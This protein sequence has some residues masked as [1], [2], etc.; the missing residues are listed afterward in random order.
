MTAHAEV[1]ASLAEWLHLRKPDTHPMIFSEVALTGKFSDAGRLDVVAV[2]TSDFY[3]KVTIHGWEVKATRSDLLSD[4]RAEKWRRYLG[5]VHRLYFA[6][7][8]G[9]AHRDEIPLECGVIIQL[10]SGRWRVVRAAPNLKSKLDPTVPWRLLRRAYH[11]R[12]YY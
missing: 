4:L 8:D 9:I 3:R 5:Q 1:A 7:P 2:W 11:G 6:F 12:G 10:S